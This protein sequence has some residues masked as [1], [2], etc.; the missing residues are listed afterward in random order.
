MDWQKYTSVVFDFDTLLDHAKRVSSSLIGLVPEYDHLGYAE[1]IYVKLLGHCVTL[2]A[3]SP[4][5]KRS[6]FTEFW[7][8]ASSSALARCA[9]EAH[10]SLMYV[11]PMNSNSGEI[12][13]RLLLW[14]LHDA[15]RRKKMLNAIGSKDPQTLEI[16]KKAELLLDKLIKHPCFEAVTPG[17]QHR[18]RNDDT[19][20]FH[21]SQ[22]DRCAADG[23]DFDFYNAV[24]MQLSQYVH[25]LPMSVHQLFLFK[26]GTPDAL[27]MMALPLQFVLAFL[28]RSTQRMQELFPDRAPSAPAEVERLIRLWSGLARKGVKGVP[29][30][31]I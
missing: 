31:T 29:K 1:Q 21:L 20:S 2:R 3:I 7:D 6:T 24:T 19:P 18:I 22:R 26:A 10:D 25:T 30:Q 5:P 14:E 4:D 27:H 15:T 11:A 9:V 8:L 13:F 16:V 12:A 17:V 28:A 23:V